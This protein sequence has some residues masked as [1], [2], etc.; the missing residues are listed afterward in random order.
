MSRSE[1]FKKKVQS[2]SL[3]EFL[4]QYLGKFELSFAQQQMVKLYD[5]S[6][7]KTEF[8]ESLGRLRLKHGRGHW[9]R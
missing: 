1:E 9:T 6:K 8:L 5:K 2:M 3:E 4:H 7:S